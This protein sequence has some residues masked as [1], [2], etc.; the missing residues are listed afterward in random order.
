MT[1]RRRFFG[2]WAGMLASA[3]IFVTGC[4]FHLQGPVKLGPQFSR[5]HLAGVDQHDV[6]GLSLK[7]YL[8]ASGVTVV[9]DPGS[10]TSI[11]RLQQDEGRRVLSVSSEGELS[12]YELFYKVTMEVTGPEQKVLLPSQTIVLTRELLFDETAVLGNES[13]QALLIE[14]MKRDMVRLVM[15]KLQSVSSTTG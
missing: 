1:M 15:L 13:E 10:A 4:G 9:E 3:S 12:E 11:V 8:Q 7:D 6:F 2:V 5:T 14:E